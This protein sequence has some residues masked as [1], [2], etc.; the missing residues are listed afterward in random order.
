MPNGSQTPCFFCARTGR[1]RSA[2][3]VWRDKWRQYYG[4]EVFEARHWGWEAQ[5]S[6]AKVVDRRYRAKPFS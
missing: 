1:K 6:E 4:D 5:G 3:H 2:E